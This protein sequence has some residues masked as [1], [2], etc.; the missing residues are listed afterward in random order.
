MKRYIKAT[1]KGRRVRYVKSNSDDMQTYDLPYEQ[2]T[3]EDY[4]A[5]ELG[6][7]PKEVADIFN[8]TPDDIRYIY[9]PADDAAVWIGIEFVDSSYEVW[10]NDGTGENFSTNDRS[11]ML[12]YASIT[13]DEY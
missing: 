11:K 13:D 10:K 6:N 7:D 1:S 5:Y 4:A 3:L 8:A 12:R 2:L 9:I